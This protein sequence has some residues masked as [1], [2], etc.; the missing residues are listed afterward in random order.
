MWVCRS[1]SIAVL[2][3][4]GNSVERGYHQRSAIS[5]AWERKDESFTVACPHCNFQPS[6]EQDGTAKSCRHISGGH[7]ANDVTEIPVLF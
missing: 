3:N 7:L 5:L 1:C 6:L 2:I 4:A